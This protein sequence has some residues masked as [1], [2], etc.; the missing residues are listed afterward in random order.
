VTLDAGASTDDRRI[1]DYAWDLD[2]DGVTDAT[3]R[4]VERPF[5]TP[6]DRSLRLTVR[7]DDGVT[8]SVTRT[9]TVRPPSTVEPTPTETAESRTTTPPERDGTGGPTTEPTPGV[10]PTSTPDRSSGWPLPGTPRDAATV[11]GAAVAVGLAVLFRDEIAVILGNLRLPRPGRRT[12][13][14]RGGRSPVTR[15]VPDPEE[16]DEDEPNRSPTASV[17]YTPDEPTAGRAVLFDG[18]GSVDPDGRVTAYRWSGDGPER[19]GATVVHAFEEDGEYDVTLVVE[20]DDGACGE[21][22]VTVEV[23]SRGGEFALISVHP[24][25]PDRDHE[26]LHLEYLTFANVGDGPL[27]VG[28]W[29]VH[30][31]A[32]EESRVREGEHTYAFE[33]GLELDPEATV[34]LYTGT[35]PADA[36][37]PD[38]EGTYHRYWGRTWPVWNNE[39]DVAVVRDADANPVLVARYA[40]SGEGYAVETLDHERLEYLFPDASTGW[41]GDEDRE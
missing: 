41:D 30:D 15:R 24:D 20:D 31:A 10:T 11:G 9:V 33:E 7:D 19:T 22:T 40:R 27:D 17:R 35:E 21:R 34:T 6:G 12:T 36:P 18:T 16:T 14:P 29:T 3:G 1:V 38:T 37:T 5:E 2:G 25:S 8:D 39:G 32:E 23:G 13:P 28:G 26:S 4:V